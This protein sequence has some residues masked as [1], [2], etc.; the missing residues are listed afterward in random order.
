MEKFKIEKILLVIE[1]ITE[2]LIFRFLRKSEEKN[3]LLYPTIEKGTDHT[4]VP[5]LLLYE[6][7]ARV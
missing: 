2:L 3:S 1:K 6:L 4:L 5:L 7:K